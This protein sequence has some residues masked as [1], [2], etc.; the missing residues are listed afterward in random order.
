[1]TVWQQPPEHQ[2]T[3]AG[4]HHLL[5]Y[6]LGLVERPHGIQ[7][8]CKTY[9]TKGLLYMLSK[10]PSVAL[11]QPLRITVEAGGS[12]YVLFCRLYDP[13]M[14]KA[15]HAPFAEHTDW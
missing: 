3:N 1:M 4:L 6:M 12:E 2:L 13:V 7:S 5:K 9:L 15:L 10:L 8:S 14:G 11:T